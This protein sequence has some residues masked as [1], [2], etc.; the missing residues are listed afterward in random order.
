MKRITLLFITFLCF[1]SFIMTAFAD[2]TVK[3]LDKRDLDWYIEKSEDG[4]T[5]EENPLAETDGFLVTITNLSEDGNNFIYSDTNTFTLF[6]MLK[7]PDAK[8]TAAVFNGSGYRELSFLEDCRG[9]PVNELGLFAQEITLPEGVDRIKVVAYLNDAL[10]KPEPGKNIQITYITVKYY[11]PDCR[12]QFLKS[13][14][15]FIDVLQQIKRSLSG[16]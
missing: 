2:D 1:V 4:F 10:E 9:I 16:E 13:D 8:V 3:A 14:R 12:E 11:S 5:E 6:G 15:R 7:D